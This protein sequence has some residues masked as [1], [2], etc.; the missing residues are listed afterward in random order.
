MPP[1]VVTLWLRR[2]VEHIKAEA[3]RLHHSHQR[4][5]SAGAGQGQGQGGGGQSGLQRVQVGTRSA[6]AG[7][8]GTREGGG[9]QA[10]QEGGKG[11]RRGVGLWVGLPACCLACRC[12]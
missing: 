3:L 8:G 11:R 12:R 10:L 5:L 6:R 9:E 2:Q 7:G 4:Q 1:W